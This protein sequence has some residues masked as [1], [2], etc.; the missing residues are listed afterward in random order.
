M[1]KQIFLKK[2]EQLNLDGVLKVQFGRTLQN[3]S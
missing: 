3:F 2:M 1:M